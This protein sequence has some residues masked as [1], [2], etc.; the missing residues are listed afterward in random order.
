MS[1]IPT[2]EA[3][4]E[5]SIGGKRVPVESLREASLK[6]RAY[7]DAN[8]IGASTMRAHD[9]KVFRGRKL[10]ARVNYNGRVWAP[11]E[12]EIAI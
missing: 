6:W 11:D 2:R 8:G 7:R 9:G 1:A 4:M 3:Q 10:V 12:T 5:V